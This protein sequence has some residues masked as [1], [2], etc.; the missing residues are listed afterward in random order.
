[1]RVSGSATELSYGMAR[2]LRAV[3]LGV[4]REI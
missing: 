1:M 4:A 2:A 3:V